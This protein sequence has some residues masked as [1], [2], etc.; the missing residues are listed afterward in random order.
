MNKFLF[1]SLATLCLFLNSCEKHELEI[2]DTY[3]QIVSYRS[4]EEINLNYKDN[5]GNYQSLSCSEV[6]LNYVNSSSIDLFVEHSDG[7]TQA[8]SGDDVSVLPTSGN[9]LVSVDNGTSITATDIVTNICR[10]ELCYNYNNGN[11]VGTGLSI[12]IEDEPSGF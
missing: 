9:L 12:V 4:A 7:S 8:L 1:A 2:G 5:A 11:Q 10:P 6:R 3:D